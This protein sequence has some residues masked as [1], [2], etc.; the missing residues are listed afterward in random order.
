MTLNKAVLCVVWCGEERLRRVLH[1]PRF[2]RGK[3]ITSLD[4]HGCMRVTYFVEQRFQTLA[5]MIVTTQSYYKHTVHK[6]TLHTYKPT[7]SRSH[8]FCMEN[9]NI[10]LWILLASHNLFAGSLTY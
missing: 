7:R 9:K 2:G 8:R 1:E 3:K 6:H 10:T 5:V 4:K